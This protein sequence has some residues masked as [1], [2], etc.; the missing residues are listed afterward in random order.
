MVLPLGRNSFPMYCI[1]LSFEHAGTFPRAT[2]VTNGD[3]FVGLVGIRDKQDLHRL[4][5]GKGS[6]PITSSPSPMS[7]WRMN[8]PLTMPFASLVEFT[9]GI[10]FCIPEAFMQL[11]DNFP[12]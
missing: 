6:W 10:Q 5:R 11:M 12:R 3:P 1:V 4:K 2:K 9:Q 8:H 7:A